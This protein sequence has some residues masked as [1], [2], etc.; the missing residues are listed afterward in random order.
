MIVTATFFDDRAYSLT[1]IPLNCNKQVNALKKT[2]IFSGLDTDSLIR[3]A[4]H[5]K[6]VDLQRSDILFQRGDE[7][8]GIY[9]VLSGQIKLALLSDHGDEKVIEIISPGMTFGEAVM[10]I[11]KPY[12]AYAMALMHT[13]LL[14][15]PKETI[16]S[17]VENQP[18]FALSML[19]GVSRRLHSLMKD[20]EMV[21]LHSSVQRVIGYLLSC[22]NGDQPSGEIQ[23]R[24]PA[25]KVIIASKLNLTPETFS[26][27]LHK[28]QQ[29]NLVTIDGR[30]IAITN[31]D[32]LKAY[33]HSE[34]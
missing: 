32:T 18:D 5:S 21:T 11:N 22:V 17:M 3:T 30:S 19:A 12:P 2:P 27:A 10:L 24:L 34:A 15:I 23:I 28:L 9:L 20:H 33:G 6:Q 13:E 26:R 25:T 31:L 7:S 16:L 29:E 4:E 14:Y 8:R 1:H